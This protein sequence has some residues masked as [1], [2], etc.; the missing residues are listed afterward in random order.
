MFGVKITNID[1]KSN[2]DKNK[3]LLV[4]EYLDKIRPY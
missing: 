3:M 1:Y 4:E 2:G